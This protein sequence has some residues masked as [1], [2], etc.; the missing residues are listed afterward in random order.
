MAELTYW[1]APTY[2]L[3]DWYSKSPEVWGRLM[4]ACLLYVKTGDKEGSAAGLYPGDMEAFSYRC[5]EI[6]GAR[7]AVQAR[8]EKDEDISRKRSDAAKARWAQQHGG[9]MQMHANASKY[10]SQYKDQNQSPPISPPRLHPRTG[11]GRKRT[12]ERA[13][14][15]AYADALHE[16]SVKDMRAVGSYLPPVVGS[17]ID[18]VSMID[19]DYRRKCLD[20]LMRMKE[21]GYEDDGVQT[22]RGDGDPALVRPG[23]EPAMQPGV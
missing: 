5:R 11:K 9:G 6:D 13:Q 4:I 2:L 12:K 21:E 1:A 10:Q 23:E 15:D 8:E 17:V 20:Q 7:A 22:V 16:D 18:G 14:D 19:E 3:E